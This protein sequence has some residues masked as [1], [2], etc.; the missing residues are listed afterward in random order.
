MKT[1]VVG[2]RGHIDRGQ[3]QTQL[4]ISGL[5]QQLY[6]HI[7]CCDTGNYVYSL[8]AIVTLLFSL[9]WGGTGLHQMNRSY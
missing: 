4:C 6:I 7:T 1:R 3:I 8:L 2:R 5:Y 9:I